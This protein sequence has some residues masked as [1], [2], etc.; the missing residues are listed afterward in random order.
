MSKKIKIHTPEVLITPGDTV[1]AIAA[2]VPTSALEAAR[3]Q[4]IDYDLPYPEGSKVESGKNGMSALLVFGGGASQGEEIASK[5]SRKYRTPAY[6]LDFDD[7]LEF[8][9]GMGIRQFEGKRYT[10]V[11]GH[12]AAFLDSHGIDAPGYEPLPESPVIS[13]GIVEGATLK[14]AS[15]ALPG[16]KEL[17]VPHSRGVL[18]KRPAGVATEQLSESLNRRSFTIFYNRRD[19]SFSCYIWKPDAKEACFAVG[20]PTH[21]YEVADSV[22]GETTLEGILRVLDIPRELLFPDPDASGAGSDER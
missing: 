17:F 19:K 13:V 1:W 20:Q 18:V 3:R 22:L 4:L 12:P 7:E 9:E 6:L 14:E 16:A 21:D 2:K 8:E 10:W 15:E 11:N 5:L